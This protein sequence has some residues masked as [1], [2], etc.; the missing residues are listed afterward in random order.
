MAPQKN[1]TRT[2]VRTRYAANPGC[3]QHSVKL[4]SKHGGRG[5][6]EAGN[7]PG[8]T[9]QQCSRRQT[10]NYKA[11]CEK[12]KTK[13][14]CSRERRGRRQLMEFN[15][16]MPKCCPGA[17]VRSG[18]MPGDVKAPDVS[19]WGDLGALEVAASEASKLSQHL[20]NPLLQSAELLPTWSTSRHFLLL[21][22]LRKRRSHIHERLSFPEASRYRYSFRLDNTLESAIDLLH[23]RYWLGSGHW[24][25]KVNN[26]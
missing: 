15:A 19:P 25:A 5:K 18:T 20:P 14:D 11:S 22:K 23:R 10:N 16:P 2:D 9:V 13:D 8:K 6:V 4:W 24:Q 7:R 17:H 3:W 26:T 12:K 21:S 1:M